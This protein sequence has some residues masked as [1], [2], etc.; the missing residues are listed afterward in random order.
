MKKLFVPYDI[1]LSLRDKGFNETCFG[2]YVTP[3]EILL[4]NTF[5]YFNNIKDIAINSQ[6]QKPT[7]PLYQ[8]VKAWLLTKGYDLHD[9][10]LSSTRT[11]GCDIYCIKD[12][13]LLEQNIATDSWEESL[14]IAIRQ[15]LNL[16]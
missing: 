7:A 14:S 8:Q 3:A 11:F 2:W 4:F 12:R 1:A 16:L 9:Y 15:A 5:G 13:G 6:Q 10:Y